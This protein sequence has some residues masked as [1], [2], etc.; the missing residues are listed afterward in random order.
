MPLQQVRRHRQTAHGRHSA[1]QR[2][3]Q[4][5]K[6]AQIG[7]H[8]GVVPHWS[9]DAAEADAQQIRRMLTVD[10]VVYGRQQA[11]VQ[12]ILEAINA[13]RSCAVVLASR[14]LAKRAY[15]ESGQVS[16]VDLCGQIEAVR[17]VAVALFGV[18]LGQVGV[19]PCDAQIVG[20]AS[21]DRSISRSNGISRQC[22]AI[23]RL[24]FRTGQR[25]FGNL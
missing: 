19:A 23:G 14:L 11:R 24:L 20:V 13:V 8:L 21:S 16:G 3:Q 22:V 15:V 1:Q 9:A 25:D 7:A 5:Q 6:A 12:C 17:R 4:G 18:D 10:F 2:S